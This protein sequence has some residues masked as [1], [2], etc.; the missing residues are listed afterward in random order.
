MRLYVKVL[1]SLPK[2]KSTR[3]TSYGALR[4]LCL[5]VCPAYKG[6][7]LHPP[8]LLSQGRKWRV[9][10]HFPE[11]VNFPG[12]GVIYTRLCFS[13]HAGASL[14]PWRWDYTL[15]PGFVTQFFFQVVCY[16]VQYSLTSG[17]KRPKRF[18]I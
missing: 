12:R 15:H 4:M 17:R 6:Y 8:L 1:C 18:K 3:L 10:K 14:S 16:T 2:T 5:L 7:G 9:D 11:H 13:S